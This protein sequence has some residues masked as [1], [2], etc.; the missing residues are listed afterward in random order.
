MLLTQIRHRL[1]RARQWVRAATEDAR[2]ALAGTRDPELPP[3]RLRFVGAGDFRSVGEEMLQLLIGTGG[4]KPSDRVLDVGSGIGRVAIPLTHYLD[5]TA[6]YDG[7][8]IV[9][10]GV[11]WCRR[12]ITPR[13]PHFRFHLAAVRNPEYNP[14]GVPA[15]EY[16]F[17]FEDASFDL[18]FATSLYTHLEL[19]E[20]RRYIA[21]THRVLAPGGTFF[22]TFFLLNDVSLTNMGTTYDFP[23]GDALVRRM[24]G[25]SAASGVA[26]DEALVVDTLRTAGFADVRVHHGQWSGRPN[27]LT[28]QDLVTARRGSQ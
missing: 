14:R 10:R 22:A 1:R 6:T 17:P 3:V 19:D 21:E 23:I 11:E 24:K 4:L 2:Q 28:F 25:A 15:A 13:H 5:A 26:F 12:E 8:D 9:R 18:A 27:G 20:L 7:F 16:R